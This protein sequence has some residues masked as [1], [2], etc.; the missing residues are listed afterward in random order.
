[1]KLNFISRKFG[2]MFVDF[3]L[4]DVADYP[5]DVC[6]ILLLYFPLLPLHRDQPLTIFL[7]QLCFAKQFT[8]GWANPLAQIGLFCGPKPLA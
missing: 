1:M 8:E 3:C 5:Q 2:S 4:S 6:Q 7:G